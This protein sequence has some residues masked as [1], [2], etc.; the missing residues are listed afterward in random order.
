M[1]YTEPFSITAAVPA[2]RHLPSII[3]SDRHRQ[4]ASAQRRLSLILLPM[5][6]ASWFLHLMI[7]TTQG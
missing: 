1:I 2:N 4:F 6:C 3:W 7:T 5:I